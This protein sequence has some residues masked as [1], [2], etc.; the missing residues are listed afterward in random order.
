MQNRYRRYNSGFT[1]VELLVVI[2]VIGILATLTIVS[3]SGISQKAIIASLQSDLT[4]ASNQIKMAQVTDSSGN[5]PD[6]DQCPTPSAGNIC[7]K[8]SSGN[9][10]A[11]TSDNI[12]NPKTFILDITNT[13]GTTYRITDDSSPVAVVSPYIQTITTASC[14]STRTQVQ[15]ARDGHTYWAQQL[16]DG[17]CWMLT[18]LGYAGGGTNTYGDVK[19]LT[20][21]TGGS[22]TYTVASYYVTPSTTNF[23]TEPTSPSTSTDG[24]G[25]YG[26][27]YNWCAATGGDLASSGCSGTISTPL[28]VTA[29]SI[30]PSGWRLP[31]SNGGEFGA[32]NTAINGGSTNTDAGLIGA[33]WLGQRGG[34]W[35]SGFYNQGSVGL[36]WSSS[37]NSATF[38]YGLNFSSTNVNP[39]DYYNKYFG[40]AVR[41]VAI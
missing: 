35:N 22:S 6:Q 4:N 34:D 16:A 31:T 3:F 15:D 18:N 40:F 20:N 12:S 41:C 9:T 25:Q 30:C 29:A 14:P 13:N 38:A 39:A 5:Y 33:P 17:K 2:V 28:P 32:L 21:G 24:T 7:L 26:Y 23:T 36:Y 10:F 37:Q 8:A 11:Y 19:T 27:L 1:I